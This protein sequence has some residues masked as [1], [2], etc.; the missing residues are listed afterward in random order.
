MCGCMEGWMYG[1]L[2]IGLRI[3]SD[4]FIGTVRVRTH[5][6]IILFVCT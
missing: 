3:C 2:D 4:V 5:E 1:S 6:P